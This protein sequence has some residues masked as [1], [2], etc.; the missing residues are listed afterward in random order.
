VVAPVLISIGVNALIGDAGDG[1]GAAIFLAMWIVVLLSYGV[2]LVIGIPVHLL[3]RRFRKTGLI[4]YLALAAFPF[5]LL[6]T[7]IAVW[8]RFGPAPAPPINPFSL[9]RQGGL[10][11]KWMLAFAAMASLCASMFWYAGVRQ[12]KS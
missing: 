3:L 7:A 1:G 9:Y 12:P 2:A 4:Y 6:A 10:V 11:I 5:L 8:V